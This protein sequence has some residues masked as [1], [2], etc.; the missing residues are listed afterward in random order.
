MAITGWTCGAL[1]EQKLEQGAGL[2]PYADR[3]PTV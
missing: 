3:T 2:Y 1:L